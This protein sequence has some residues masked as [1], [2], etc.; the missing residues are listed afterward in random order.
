MNTYRRTFS[1]TCPSNGIEVTYLLE[2]T[3]N[4]VIM[5]E[6]IL[7]ATESGGVDF[8][9]KLADRLWARFPGTRQVLK[10]FHHGVEIE[11]IRE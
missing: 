11:T 10:A 8:H 1:R 3:T 4:L 5:V 7:K 2:M 9:E 6:D